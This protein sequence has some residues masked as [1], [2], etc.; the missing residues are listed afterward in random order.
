MVHSVF[1]LEGVHLHSGEDLVSDSGHL[2]EYLKA[3]L[4]RESQHLQDSLLI[5]HFSNFGVVRIRD[6]GEEFHPA[7]RSGF[8]K[9]RVSYMN[10]L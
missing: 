6:E 10:P 2:I 9:R 8:K 1:S 7:L 4:F 5:E 3:N